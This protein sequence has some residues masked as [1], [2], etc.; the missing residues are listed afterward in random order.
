MGRF[1]YHVIDA[2]GHGGEAAN[3]R[4]R[5]PEAFKARMAEYRDRIGKHYGKL[6]LPGGGTSRPGD[7]FDMRPGMT[8]PTERIKDMDLEGID[9][10]VNFPGGAGE[11]WAML[12]R[13]FSIALCRTMNDAKAEFNKAAPARIKAIAKLPMIDPA[14]AAAEL[15]RAVTELGLVGMVTPQHIRDKN[16]SDPSFDVV[17]AEAERLGATVCVHGGGQAPDQYPIG[18]DRF[19]TRL[20]VHAMTHP[21][22]NMLALNCFTV[23]GVLHRFPK[24]HV[25]FMES[26]CGWLPYWLDR[27]D[28]HY[29][30]M[31]EQAPGIDRKPSQYFLDGNCFISCEPDEEILPYVIKLCGDRNLVYASD[32]YHWDCKF[33]DTVKMVAERNDISADCKKRILSE[34]AARMYPLIGQ[35]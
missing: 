32:Y 16:L 26:G 2:D 31:P 20:E 12:D 30:L 3:W 21:M 9:V 19:H 4:D 27:L 25:G 22:G 5:I 23:G 34:N 14:A 28:E 24:L 35:A 17:W 6:A 11:E 1:G 33:P 7:K 8:D 10:T 29:E 18:V 15:R 13:D